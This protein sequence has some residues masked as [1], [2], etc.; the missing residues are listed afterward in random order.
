MGV[1]SAQDDP[2]LFRKLLVDSGMQSDLIEHIFSKRYSMIA[3]LGFAVPDVAMVEEFLKVL[4]CGRNRCAVLRRIVRDCIEVC[5]TGIMP[6]HFR[7]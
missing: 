7:T 1:R 3:L 6:P 4:L 2:E 5:Q